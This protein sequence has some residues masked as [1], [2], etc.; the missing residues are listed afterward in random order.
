MFR[1]KSLADDSR[2]AEGFTIGKSVVRSMFE[3]TNTHGTP[4]NRKVRIATVIFKINCTKRVIGRA[5]VC[6]GELLCDF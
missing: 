3:T 5:L 6:L 1:V 4:D 2:N